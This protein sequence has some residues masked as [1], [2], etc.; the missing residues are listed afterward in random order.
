M[1]FNLLLVLCL[2]TFVNGAGAANL[3]VMVEGTPVHLP[4]PTGSCGLDTRYEVDRVMFQTLYAIQQQQNAGDV[5]ILA[6]HMNCE[7]LYSIR[8]GKNITGIPEYGIYTTPQP[9]KHFK[10]TRFKFIELAEQDHIANWKTQNT[11]L[12]KMLHDYATDIP[13]SN[14]KDGIISKDEL[15]LYLGIVI[16][17]GTVIHCSVGAV[18]LIKD[19]PVSSWIYG[20]ITDTQSFG[21][22]VNKAK[23][24]VSDLIT[25]N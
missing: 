4:M 17:D 21:I 11:Q 9:T 3:D 10:D 6:I 1:R 2:S 19:I 24:L 5:L 13:T 8:N 7:Q 16:N 23:L 18:T 22:L 15:A 20:S 25:A 12:S 14:I